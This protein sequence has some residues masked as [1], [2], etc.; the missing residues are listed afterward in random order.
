MVCVGVSVGAYYVRLTT[1]S[2]RV[3]VIDSLRGCVFPSRMETRIK[4]C[5]YVEL[6]YVGYLR[7]ERGISGKCILCRWRKL[8][9]VHR[10]AFQ[11]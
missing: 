10:A 6:E 5:R 3:W 1:S 11:L 4:Q 8:L 7:N 2:K 9:S